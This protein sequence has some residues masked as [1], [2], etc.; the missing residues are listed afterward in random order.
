MNVL[1]RL[2]GNGIENGQRGMTRPSTPDDLITRDA[3]GAARPG[4]RPDPATH[5][6]EA[7]LDAPAKPPRS[8]DVAMGAAPDPAAERRA[9][10]AEAVRAAPAAEK[11]TPA[12]L[13]DRATGGYVGWVALVFGL[14][15]IVGVVAWLV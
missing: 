3:T 15:V 6:H 12:E 7:P 14:L 13:T 5:G 8:A 1:L 2:C 11:R 4:D 9:R 10:Q